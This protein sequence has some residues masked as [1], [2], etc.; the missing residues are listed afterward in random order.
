MKR[1]VGKWV[2]LLLCACMLSGC[3]EST[4]INPPTEDIYAKYNLP[5]PTDEWLVWELLWQD[6]TDYYGDSEEY[7]FIDSLEGEV[8]TE[9]RTLSLLMLTNQIIT[10]EEAIEYVKE[11]VEG[12]A[13]LIHEQNND[14]TEAGEGTY[15]SYLDMYEITLIVAPK[16]TEDDPSTWIFVDTLPKEGYKEIGAEA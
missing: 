4:I 8:D 9:N 3:T 6:M 16:E 5:A 13:F 2:A 7:P 11:V 14:Y 15:G 12:F 10:R 1:T